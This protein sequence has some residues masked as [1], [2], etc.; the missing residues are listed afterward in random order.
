LIAEIH[1]VVAPPW[2]DA[3]MDE[4]TSEVPEAV[5]HGEVLL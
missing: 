1:G 3:V 5:T 4:V 2:E